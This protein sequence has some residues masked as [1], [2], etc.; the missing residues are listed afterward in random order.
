[1]ANLKRPEFKLSSNVAENF[2][3]FEMR[4]NDYCFQAEYRDLTEDPAI[5]EQRATHYIKPQLEIAAIWSALSDE[6]LQV[7][8]YTIIPRYWW[9]TIKSHGSG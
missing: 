6:L 5:L 3:N 2:K 4:F 1:M 8:Q 7:L 9:L